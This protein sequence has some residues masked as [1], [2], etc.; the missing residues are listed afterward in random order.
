M[1]GSGALRCCAG[2]SPELSGAARP[3][4]EAEEER[5]PLLGAAGR[6]GSQAAAAGVF[7]GRRVACGA[8]LLAELL[9]RA[10]FYG[11]TSN[12]VLFLNGPP[13]VWEG[14]QASQALL[15]FMGVTY[16]VSPFGGWLADARLGKFGT[17]LLSMALYL[18]G[19]LAFPTMAS[20]RGRVALCGALPLAPVSNCSRP[21][22]PAP[23]TAPPCA[24]A[25]P[26]RYCASA[27]FAGLVLVGLGVGSLKANITPFG[28][29]QV[30]GP[31]AVGG[32]GGK[33]R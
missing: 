21:P 8:V 7:A 26:P 2:A 30:R 5:R 12:L 22:A 9:E 18:L 24:P 3:M 27:A 33:E 17:I 32:W 19:M 20:P 23:A 31:P 13:Y 11:V 14:A 25:A 15:L 1:A 28:A 16:L 10:A 6:R 4:A 29:D